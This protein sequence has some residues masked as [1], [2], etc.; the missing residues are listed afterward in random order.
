MAKWALAIGKAVESRTSG[1][2][3]DEIEDQGVELTVYDDGPEDEATFFK[4][5]KQ[6]ATYRVNSDGSRERLR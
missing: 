3:L 4:D 6:V 1:R 2:R 5:G